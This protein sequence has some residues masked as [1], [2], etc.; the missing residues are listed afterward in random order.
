MGVGIEILKFVFNFNMKATPE[1]KLNYYQK[2]LCVPSVKRKI[3][4]SGLNL[5]DFSKLFTK[6]L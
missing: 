2:Q 5:G 3:I 6:G 4:F 1:A